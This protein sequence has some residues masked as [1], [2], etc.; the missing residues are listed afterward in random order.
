MISQ[1]S[2]LNVVIGAD[3][4]AVS[5]HFDDTHITTRPLGT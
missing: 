3:T 4:A 1:P 2:V 5:D